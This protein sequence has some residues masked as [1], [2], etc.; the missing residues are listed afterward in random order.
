MAALVIGQLAVPFRF[1]ENGRTERLQH[2]FFVQPLQRNLVR[3]M[4]TG[5]DLP[6]GSD[7]DPVA[8]GTEVCADRADEADVSLC[9]G[10]PI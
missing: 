6:V 9:V 4:K 5:L 3:G 10:K 1:G 2:A 7:A 8:I